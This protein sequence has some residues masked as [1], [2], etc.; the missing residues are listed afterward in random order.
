MGVLVRKN[1]G[2]IILT[3]I[4]RLAVICFL[5]SFAAAFID[6][7]WA[8]YMEKFLGNMSWVGFFSSFLT[9]IAFFSF[10]FFIPFIEKRNKSKLYS[11]SLVLFF[12][13]YLLFAINRNPYIFAA[14]AIATTVLS[15]LKITSFGII[16]RDKSRE[17]EL[18]RNEGVMYTLL[19]VAWV[20]GPLVAGL[21]SEFLGL[22][23]IFVISA[24]FMF[25]AL[26]SFKVSRIQDPNLKKKIDKNMFKNFKEFFRNKHRV[27]SY[28]IGGGV[29]FWWGLIYLFVPM[30]I[31][32]SGLSIEWVGY[33]LFAIAVPLILFT[34]VFAKLAGKIGFKKLFKAGFFILF[35]SAIACFFISGFPVILGIN[36]IYIILGVLVLASIGAA[37]LESTAE[38]YFFD[39]VKGKEEL[40]FYGPY[41][42]NLEV[43]RLI[44]Y[45]VP[46]LILLFLPFKFIF[47]FFA[48]IMLS[49][50]FV[51]FKIKE[52]I[53]KKHLHYHKA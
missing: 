42:T 4:A 32:K 9:I 37:M 22:S 24:I 30:Y 18:S 1:Q 23:F 29:P 51:C 41:N 46:S 45:F 14:L 12:F 38:A 50:F 39:L 49:L 16:I 36:N 17:T 44:A 34:Y 27:F 10:F 3:R 52:V 20:V 53:E 2:N 21:L 26:I 47:L 48:A 33:F 6:T 31:I 7:I 40:H 11:L 5:T 13:A 19:N 43:S 25:L 8:V 15:T 28:I 35:A